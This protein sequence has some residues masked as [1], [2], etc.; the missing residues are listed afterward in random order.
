M[1]NSDF[2]GPPLHWSVLSVVGAIATVITLIF[3]L[4]IVANRLD[5]SPTDTLKATQS[6]PPKAVP[7]EATD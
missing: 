1:N 7:P 3:A 6:V 2:E 4:E 5:T